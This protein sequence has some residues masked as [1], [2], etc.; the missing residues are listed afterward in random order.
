M[1]FAAGP[2]AGLAEGPDR[3]QSGITRSHTHTHTRE[4]VMGNKCV[5]QACSPRGITGLSVLPAAVQDAAGHRSQHSHKPSC[6]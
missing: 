3:D 4:N 2:A 1:S 6:T 5:S